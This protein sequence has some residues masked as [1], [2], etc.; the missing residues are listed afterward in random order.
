MLG[1]TFFE[2]KKSDGNFLRA[3]NIMKEKHVPLKLAEVGET[4]RVRE[5]IKEREGVSLRDSFNHNLYTNPVWKSVDKAKWRNPKGMSY[6][7]QIG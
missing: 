3:K 4:S 6:E 7:G 1:S 2:E 5:A